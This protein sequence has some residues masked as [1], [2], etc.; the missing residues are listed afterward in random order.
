MNEAMRVNTTNTKA[1]TRGKHGGK[2]NREQKSF[3]GF[4]PRLI[5]EKNHERKLCEARISIE[6]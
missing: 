6:K 4:D 1:V 5:R 2:T 3:G